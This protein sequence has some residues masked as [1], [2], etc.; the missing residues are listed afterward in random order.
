[1]PSLLDRLLAHPGLFILALLGAGL[2]ALW[3]AR[4][5]RRIVGLVLLLVILAAILPGPR[6]AGV[7]AAGL[8]DWAASS[9]CLKAAG[10][11]PGIWRGAVEAEDLPA[12]RK[13]LPKA[14]SKDMRSHAGGKRGR[15]SSG[16]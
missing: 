15:D 13:A 2:L 14:D 4:R 5:V 6:S 9:R 11:D 10:A 8:G 7:A 12:C 3:L 16:G 1:M